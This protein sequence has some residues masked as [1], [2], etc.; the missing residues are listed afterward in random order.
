MLIPLLL[1]AF[2]FT[3]YFVTVMLIRMRNEILERERHT[4]WVAQVLESET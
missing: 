2:A 3:F 4:R 1:M